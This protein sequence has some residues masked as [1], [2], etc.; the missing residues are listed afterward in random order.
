MLL[1]QWWANF[2][3]HGQRWVLKFDKGGGARADGAFWWPSSSATYGPR[4][5]VFPS[6]VCEFPV[7][8]HFKGVFAITRTFVSPNELEKQ[9]KLVPFIP[10]L[11]GVLL[12]SSRDWVLLQL[13]RTFSFGRSWHNQPIMPFCIK[14]WGISANLHRW[15]AVPAPRQASLNWQYCKFFYPQVITKHKVMD[16]ISFHPAEWRYFQSIVSSHAELWCQAP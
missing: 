6:L 7:F 10:P 5:V 2:L 15:R 12:H 11:N 8:K 14:Y 3:T 4:A 13:E 16:S 9:A 1:F